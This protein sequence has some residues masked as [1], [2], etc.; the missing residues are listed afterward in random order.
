MQKQAK[1]QFP[2]SKYKIEKR[3]TLNAKST[4]K[5]MECNYEYV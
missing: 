4:E 1:Q 2:R 3:K 5:S